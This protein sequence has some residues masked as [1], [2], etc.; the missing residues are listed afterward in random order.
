MDGHLMVYLG[1][2]DGDPYVISS[3]AAFIEP[4]HELTDIRQAN[5]V[6]VS[7]LELLRSNGK[8]WLED[9]CYILWKEY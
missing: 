7:N 4:D 9:I 3:C 1:S 8:T 5:C 6:F 2:V